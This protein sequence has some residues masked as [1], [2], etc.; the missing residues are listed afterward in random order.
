MIHFYAIVPVS[1]TGVEGSLPAAGN[2]YIA[3]ATPSAQIPEPPT[4]VARDRSGR[5][6]VR[7]DVPEMR[8]RVGRVEILR[9]PDAQRAI[10]PEHAGPPVAVLDA[11]PAGASARGIHFEFEDT[12]GQDVESTFYR[13]IAWAEASDRGLHP[14]ARHRRDRSSRRHLQRSPTLT[15][16]T[17]RRRG[18][19]DHRRGLRDER[20]LQE[21]PRRTCSRSRGLPDGLAP[22][23]RAGCLPLIAERCLPDGA[24]DSIFRHHATD[25]AWDGRAPGAA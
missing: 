10:M 7:V 1:V 4:L 6:S 17:L 9:A 5:V 13:A 19:S 16:L 14:G 23:G 11:A 8:V 21:T 20:P 12:T 22:A 3:V 2:D 25:P 18:V 24:T 15:A